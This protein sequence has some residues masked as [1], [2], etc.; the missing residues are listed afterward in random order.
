M[1]TC[2]CATVGWLSTILQMPCSIMIS[3]VDSGFGNG[4][5]QEREQGQFVHTLY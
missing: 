1:Y 3:L 2:T 5:A 4:K